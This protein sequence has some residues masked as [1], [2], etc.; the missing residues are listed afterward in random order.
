MNDHDIFKNIKN[1]VTI[2][3]KNK[4]MDECKFID[5]PINEKQTKQKQKWK[6]QTE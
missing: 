5:K 3:R 1:K 4:R 6:K 2:I